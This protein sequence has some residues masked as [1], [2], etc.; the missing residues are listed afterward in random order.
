MHRCVESYK[1][2]RDIVENGELYRLGTP[3]GNDFYGA[4]YVTPDKSRAVVFTYCIGF[5]Q[6]ACEGQS[7]RLKGLDPARRYRVTEQ[8]VDESCYTPAASNS[9]IKLSLLEQLNIALIQAAER[10]K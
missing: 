10:A 9:S 6:L 5:R 2:F 3:W 1:G 8:N 7:F 4:M